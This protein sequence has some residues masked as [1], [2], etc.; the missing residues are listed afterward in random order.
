[1]K[2][3][4]TINS[5]TID[6]KSNNFQHLITGS[7]SAKIASY[8]M[9]LFSLGFMYYSRENIMSVFAILLGIV[10]QL[11]YTIKYL[12][13]KGFSQNPRTSAELNSN[14]SR[15]KTYIENR[16]KYEFVFFII[17]LISFIPAAL[18]H[19]DSGYRVAI[20]G[21]AYTA[22]VGIFG[23]FAFKKVDKEIG[24]LEAEVKLQ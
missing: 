8:V 2:N 20:A 1:M 11:F 24:A 7:K 18:Q 21:I 5:E 10:A 6:M 19:F 14:L 23:Y 9:I 4:E 15:F 17:W 13:L 16:K 12:N 3:L 22:F